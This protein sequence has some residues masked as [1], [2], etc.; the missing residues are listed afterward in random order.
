ML[1][2]LSVN[3]LSVYISMFTCV[4]LSVCVCVS[5][6]CLCMAYVSSVCA[7]A[8]RQPIAAAGGVELVAA[9]LRRHADH[10]GVAEAACRA[11]CNL[12]GA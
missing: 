6:V 4:C 12:S 9:A 10:A 7:E 3:S 11:L 1:L 2:S 8:L 5:V